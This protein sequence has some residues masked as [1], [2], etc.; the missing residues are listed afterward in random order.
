MMA[1]SFVEFACLIA[2][3]IFL[4][5]YPVRSEDTI[6]S[7]TSLRGLQ[8]DSFPK[9]RPRII[10]GEI[11]KEGRFPYYAVM[12]KQSL[13]GAVLIAPRFV[14]TAA[15]CQDADDDFALGSTT[16]VGGTEFKVADRAVHP[17]YDDYTFDNDVALFELAED[18][19][20]ENSL[21]ELV[22]VPYVKLSSSEITDLMIGLSLTVIGFGD[23]NPEESD[24]E[25]SDNLRQ[26]DIGYISNT[27]CNRDHRGEITDQM[28]C[29]EAPDKDACYGDSGGPLLLTPNED[30]EDDQLVGIV[31]WGR[32]CADKDFSGV[33]TRI[34]AFYDWIVGTMCVLNSSAVPPYVDCNAIMGLPPADREETLPVVV[35]ETE[36]PT[37][38]P[39]VSPTVAQTAT[40]TVSP[41]ATPTVSPTATPTVS[42]TAAPTASPTLAPVS[43]PSCGN[44]GT[45]CE[46]DGD[47]CSNR[48]NV[49]SQECFPKRN[50]N[51]DKLSSGLGGSAG[52]TVYRARNIF[53]DLP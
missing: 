32:G 40:P 39:T 20:L 51:R 8:T 45:K 25:F 27:E 16:F 10:G 18:A 19:V 48:C 53:L 36:A 46:D 7:K 42:P 2:T 26:V 47:C 22:P 52:G 33:Y 14:L 29:A 1:P 24:T 17:L 11:S 9:K 28:M 4:A 50:G 12:K 5:S 38:A 37:V 43:S 49:F 44:R 13:C 3:I 35:V 15:H 21:G 31:S 6:A 34:S 30:Y 41:T 23:I